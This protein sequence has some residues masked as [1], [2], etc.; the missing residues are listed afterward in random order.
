M[1][2][3]A[4]T[5]PGSA[6]ARRIMEHVE[7]LCE[8]GDRFAG[9]PGDGPAA[10]YVEQSLRSE[11]LQIERSGAE[12]IT[13]REDHCSLALADGTPLD[14]TSAY[15]SPSTPGPIDA[16]LIYIGSGTEQSFEG[17]DVRGAI[18][19]LE[20]DALGYELFWLGK[21]AER[22]AARGAAGIVVIHPFPWSYRMTMEFGGADL[23]KPFAEPSVPSVAISA[24]SALRMMSAIAA[25]SP[26]ARFDLRTVV[27]PCMS[28]SVAGVLPGTK[29]PEQR[30][31]VLAHR[32]IPIVPG[33]ND[34]GS[35]TA[36]ILELARMLADHPAERS[37]VLLSV[38]GEEGRAQGTARYIEALGDEIANVKAAI[39]IDMIAAG[40]P[41]RIVEEIHWP[42]R[43]K[44]AAFTDW[45]ME[46]LEQSADRF[47]YQLE[48]Y[49]TEAG[50]DAGRFLDAGAPSAWFWKPD[51]FRYHSREDKPE[52]MD[53]NAV[54]ATAEIVADTILTIAGAHDAQ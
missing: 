48:R 2:T 36:A 5:A 43:P 51:D 47:G 54:K 31:I 12:L 7:R 32:D 14:A 3:E 37:I 9:Q 13:F 27:A 17:S 41:L 42:D 19:V 28:D 15:Y 26:M 20:E 25:G 6:N 10:D 39:S 35:G 46:M 24:T 1:T 49:R 53:A 11:G 23:S 44:P 52:Y 34:N 30:V 40:G 29:H 50:A 18:V 8:L 21:Y 45:L 22:A 33:A 38:A 4:T 16:P